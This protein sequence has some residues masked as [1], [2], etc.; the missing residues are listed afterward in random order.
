MLLYGL[1]SLQELTNYSHGNTTSLHITPRNGR[2]IDLTTDKS[3]NLLCSLTPVKRSNETVSS[4]M[5]RQCEFQLLDCMNAHNT[6]NERQLLIAD[7]AR[8]KGDSPGRSPQGLHTTEIKSANFIETF[9]CLRT[10]KVKFVFL[11]IVRNNKK[12]LS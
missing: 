10:R 3:V 8:F 11:V 2:L 5:H 9:A 1:S 6:R 7:R 4:S 12:K